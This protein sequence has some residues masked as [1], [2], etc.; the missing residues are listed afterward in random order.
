MADLKSSGP[1]KGNKYLNS[2]NKVFFLKLASV[3][4]EWAF[5]RTFTINT[6]TIPLMTEFLYKA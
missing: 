5:Q 6:N 1:T 4:C 2:I 3:V